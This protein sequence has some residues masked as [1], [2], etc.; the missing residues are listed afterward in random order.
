M[1]VCQQTRTPCSSYQASFVKGNSNLPPDKN[2]QYSQR[3]EIAPR[4]KSSFIIHP[5]HIARMRAKTP[6]RARL[7]GSVADEAP[8]GLTTLVSVEIGLP[9]V[10]VPDGVGVFVS[11]LTVS[12][13]VGR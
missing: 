1:S 13:G 12:V 3:I 10:P 8:L 5:P 9:P 11:G 7:I 6:A 4:I 2:F